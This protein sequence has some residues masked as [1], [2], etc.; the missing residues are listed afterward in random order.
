MPLAHGMQALCPHPLGTQ[1]ST[2]NRG[3]PVMVMI[4][5][6]TSSSAAPRRRPIPIRASAAGGSRHAAGG[7]AHGGSS[8]AGGHAAGSHAAHHTEHPHHGHERRQ[9]DPRLKAVAMAPK[10][11]ILSTAVSS[12]SYQMLKVA[13]RAGTP[14]GAGG[15]PAAG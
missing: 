13:R 2:T 14:G 4:K 3:S 5:L 11:H 12:A 9:S 8:H 7:H 1:W 6:R 10:P 15:K